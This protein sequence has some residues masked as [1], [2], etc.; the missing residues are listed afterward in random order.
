MKKLNFFKRVRLLQYAQATP[1]KT[2]DNHPL[3]FELFMF[4]I[5]DK[6]PSKRIN[7]RMTIFPFCLLSFI[8]CCHFS[9]QQLELKLA[10]Y[11]VIL[12]NLHTRPT[13]ASAISRP[14]YLLAATLF[15]NL[16]FVVVNS[17]HNSTTW[18][19]YN[20]TQVDELSKTS[21]CAR[22]WNSTRS[23]SSNGPTSALTEVR[24]WPGNVSLPHFQMQT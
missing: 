5:I 1:V 22:F 24:L 10:N 2:E 15:T 6:Y 18:H 11:C 21:A 7:S 4:P 20:Q 19:A 13:M 14:V 8:P 3:D 12:Q 23:Q 16:C 9:S 17:Q